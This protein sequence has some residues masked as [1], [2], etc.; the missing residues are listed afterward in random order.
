MT[1]QL[2]SV[3]MRSNLPSWAPTSNTP[4]LVHTQVH[5]AAVLPGG[6]DNKQCHG[7]C[8]VLAVQASDSEGKSRVVICVDCVILRRFV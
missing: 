3:W 8:L 4:G 5:S 7:V 1:E 2:R 6:A